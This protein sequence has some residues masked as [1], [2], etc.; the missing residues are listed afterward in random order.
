MK[1]HIHVSDYWSEFGDIL[2][3]VTSY[4]VSYLLCTALRKV[5]IYIYNR[6]MI[7]T[8][9]GISYKVLGPVFKRTFKQ[10]LEKKQ[11][12]IMAEKT[13]L[14]LNMILLEHTFRCWCGRALWCWCG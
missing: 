2:D 1:G 14:L 7:S 6:P 13:Q 4:R 10:L 8:N 11:P 9:L 12:Y 5:F 3:L